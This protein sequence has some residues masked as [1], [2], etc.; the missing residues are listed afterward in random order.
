ML[1]G[2]VISIF[3]TIWFLIN[4]RESERRKQ[5]KIFQLL[6]FIVNSLMPLAFSSGKSHIFLH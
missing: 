5:T 4:Q 2:K 3:C 1:D 6:F